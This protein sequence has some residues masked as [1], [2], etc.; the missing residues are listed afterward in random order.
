MEPEEHHAES[1]NDQPVFIR[2]LADT[3]A[4]NFRANEFTLLWLLQY[5]RCAARVFARHG[6]ACL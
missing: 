3:I 6:N 2:A 1:L 4:Y 5:G